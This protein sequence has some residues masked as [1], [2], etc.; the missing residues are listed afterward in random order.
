M[1]DDIGLFVEDADNIQIAV[2]S[3][4]IENEMVTASEAAI[5]PHQR[6]DALPK[7]GIF[8]DPCEGVKRRDT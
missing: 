6:I 5:T 7:A 8:R 2:I 3:F 1:P 4:N